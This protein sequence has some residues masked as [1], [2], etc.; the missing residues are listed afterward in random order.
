MRLTS[1]KCI[2][3]LLNADIAAFPQDLLGKYINSQ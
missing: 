2:R 1:V 3:L